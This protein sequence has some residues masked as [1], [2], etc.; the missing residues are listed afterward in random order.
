MKR[1]IIRSLLVI[2]LAVAVFC[3]I[4]CKENDTISLTGKFYGNHEATDINGNT[5]TYYEF[6][7]NDGS[8][9][10]DL[11]EYQMG[12]IPNRNAEYVFTYDNKG[13]TK[14][15]KPCDCAP[16]FE[17]ECEVYDD[18]FVGIRETNI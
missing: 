15:N 10:W 3:S 8:I 14:A 1:V 2:A 13:T 7:S 9:W 17:C 5:D 18:V 4:N 11:T 12:F 6:R 16:E